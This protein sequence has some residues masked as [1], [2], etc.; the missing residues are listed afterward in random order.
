MTGTRTYFGAHDM[1]LRPCKLAAIL[2]DFGLEDLYV[3]AM[4]AVAFDIC[5]D[6]KIADITHAIPSFDIELAA[7]IL[8][9]VFRY[10][11]R[12]TI[13]VVVVDPGVGSSRKAIAIA[14]TNYI[15]IGPDNGVLLPA[16]KNDGI[17]D[18]RIIEN[19]QLFRKPVSKSFHGRDIFMPVAAHIVC[20]TRLESVGRSIGAESLSELDIGVGY[21]KKTQNNCV[22]LKAIYIDKFGNVILSSTF[23]QLKQTLNI[24]IGTIVRVYVNKREFLARVEEVFSITPKGTLVLYENSFGFAELSVNQGSAK[25]L[26]DVERKNNIVICS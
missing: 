1:Y 19:E 12:G 21:I 6:I 23:N 13:F 24:D 3:A 16:A 25:R 20:G 22:Q 7:F 10:F 4:K 9:T 11:P 5:P 8:Y 14:T 17:V 18:I 15:F 26:L 2:T